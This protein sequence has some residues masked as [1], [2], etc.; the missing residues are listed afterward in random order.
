MAALDRWLSTGKRGVLR[1]AS[2]RTKDHH[3]G[4]A[5]RWGLL[6]GSLMTPDSRSP[7]L[8]S[9]SPSSW[10]TPCFLM[11]TTMLNNSRLET[12]LHGPHTLSSLQT[13]HLCF[14]QHVYLTSL[15]YKDDPKT[16][17]LLLAFLFHTQISN[18]F[19]DTATWMTCWNLKLNISKNKNHL[20]FKPV[21]FHESPF[22]SSTI[23][24]YLFQLSGSQNQ[25]S[26]ISLSFG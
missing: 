22:L 5:G 25:S 9:P 11:T 16:I 20:P 15:P 14:P 18:D 8:S 10:E 1:A 12:L 7:D 24:N 13:T 3:S 6:G 19:L 23:Y 4:A 26:Y 17:F 21:P 2:Q